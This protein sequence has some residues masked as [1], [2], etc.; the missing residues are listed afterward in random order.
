[1]SIHKLTA[2]GGYDYLTR[3]VAALD[4][5]ERGHTTL[6]S[7]YS[8]KGEAPG[9]WVG[10][11]MAGLEGLA[12]GDPV[13]AEQMRNLFG[14]GRHPLAEQLRLAVT[15]DGGSEAEQGAAARLGTPFRVYAGDVSTFRVEVARRVQD[16]NRARGQ[17]LDAPV[18]LA[19]RARIRTA[20]ATE[21][22]RAAH[23]RD[24]ADARELAATI[25]KCSRSRT[26]AVAA[27]DRGPGPAAS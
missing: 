4:A 20:V 18:G 11:G 17:R 16:L 5:T 26:N 25:A 22:F 21:L 15:F 6:A 23:G 2:G 13:T 10:A 1:M 8:A 27:I 24:P 9:V 14:T 12:A 7:H 19:D 3:K